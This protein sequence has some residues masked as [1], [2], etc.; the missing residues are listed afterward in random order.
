M[1]KARLRR[2]INRMLAPPRV[3]DDLI[4]HGNLAGFAHA[5]NHA[6]RV[7]RNHAMGAQFL[8]RRKVGAVIHDMRRKVVRIAMSGQHEYCAAAEIDRANRR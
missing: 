3:V 2:I 8:Q 7:Q 1:V 6:H 4:R 5:R